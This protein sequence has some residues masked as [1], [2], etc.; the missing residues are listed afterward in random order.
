MKQKTCSKNVLCARKLFYSRNDKGF[1]KS[2]KFR[3]SKELGINLWKK[4]ER[5]SV[6]YEQRPPCPLVVNSITITASKEI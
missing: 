5:E 4:K 3:H 1:S 2:A 6:F